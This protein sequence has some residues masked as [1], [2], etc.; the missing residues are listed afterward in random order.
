MLICKMCKE[1]IWGE[2]CSISLNRPA[3]NRE[4][5]IECDLC[6]ICFERIYTFCAQNEKHDRSRS[7]RI[8]GPNDDI[9]FETWQD[10]DRTT[11]NVERVY[12]TRLDCM[13]VPGGARLVA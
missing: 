6:S 9:S 7:N 8:D 2:C 5:Y 1:E 10:E 3:I 12:E 4:D 13:A 11:T